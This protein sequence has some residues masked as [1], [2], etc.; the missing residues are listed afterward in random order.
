MLGWPT[1]G[2]QNLTQAALHFDEV[3]VSIANQ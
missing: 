1:T 2:G 3:G